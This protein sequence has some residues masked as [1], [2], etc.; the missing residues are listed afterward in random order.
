MV[1]TSS[2]RHPEMNV[3][4]FENVSAG[5]LGESAPNDDLEI[6]LEAASVTF[7]LGLRTKNVKGILSLGIIW[8]LFVGSRLKNS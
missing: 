1:H 7:L 8:I 3:G 6:F 4:T 5:F 2:M